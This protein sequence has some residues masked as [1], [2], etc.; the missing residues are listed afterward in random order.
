MAL[1]TSTKPSFTRVDITSQIR[2]YQAA[3]DQAAGKIPPKALM[4][5]S[6]AY[7]AHLPNIRLNVEGAG[8]NLGFTAVSLKNQQEFLSLLKALNITKP[9]EISNVIFGLY[10]KICVNRELTPGSSGNNFN[11][12]P[13]RASDLKS[14]SS[15]PQLSSALYGKYVAYR[16]SGNKLE[17]L[18][19][20]Q[21]N[22]LDYLEFHSPHAQNAYGAQ[23]LSE[24]AETRPAQGINVLDTQGFLNALEKE[25]I[26][27]SA[28][29]YAEL[30]LLY[31]DLS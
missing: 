2:K 11:S 24:A 7:L 5:I 23:A 18:F 27:S 17:A 12:I 22:A 3:H 6:G 13:V 9:E 16:N 20:K 8:G 25:G 15:D 21:K 31:G 4:N 10:Q 1:A 26:L 30:N 29:G 14:M 19:K 28:K